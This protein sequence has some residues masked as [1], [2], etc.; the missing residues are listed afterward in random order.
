MIR[1]LLLRLLARSLRAEL[2]AA[3][4]DAE[5]EAGAYKRDADQFLRPEEPP[6]P[7]RFSGLQNRGVRLGFWWGWASGRSSALHRLQR[8]LDLTPPPPEEDKP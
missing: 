2:S 7:M 3:I 5:R 8:T 1:R 6:L 4:A